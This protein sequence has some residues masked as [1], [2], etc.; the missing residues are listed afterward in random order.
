MIEGIEQFFKLIGTAQ[1]HLQGQA[2]EDFITDVC[3]EWL[4]YKK[5]VDEWAKH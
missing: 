4:K 1:Y 3:K 5:K 2:Q